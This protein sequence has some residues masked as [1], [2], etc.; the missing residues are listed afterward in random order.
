MRS[1][2]LYLPQ[3]CGIRVNVICP[4]MTDTIMVSGFAAAWKAE[5]LP[6]NTA[7]DVARVALGVTCQDDMN[8]KSLWVEG[9]RAWE[10]EDKIDLLEPQ[11]LG[12]QASQSLARG[13]ALLGKVSSYW[14]P[15]HRVCEGELT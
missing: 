14:L 7:E 1:L 5:G 10:V 3:A 6:V 8:G 11:W 9:G 12:K 2:R 15:G 13:Q 4:W